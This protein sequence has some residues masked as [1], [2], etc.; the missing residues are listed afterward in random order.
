MD[1][2]RRIKSLIVRRRYR[3]T[4]KAADELEVDNLEEEDVFE[5]ILNA[6]RISKTLRSTSRSGERLYVIESANYKGTLIYS[7]GAIRQD[8][9]E[10]VYYI[11]ISAKRSRV[12]R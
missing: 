10:E 1:V 9:G 3:F 6:T 12:G 8:A 4:V 5:S 11:F 7:K 2:L